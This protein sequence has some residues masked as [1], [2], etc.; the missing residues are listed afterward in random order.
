MIG[1]SKIEGS[2]S[3]NGKVAVV[4]G[5]SRGI[6]RA[7]CELLAKKGADLALVALSETVESA[8]K[9]IS[10]RY[11]VRALPIRGD[12]SS[13]EDVDRMVGSTLD[14]YGKA[15]ILCA[16]AGVTELGD[17]ESIP[18]ADWDR[19][20]NI[21]ARG[22]F[23]TAQKFGAQMIRAG[24]GG[25]IVVMTSQGGIVALDKH[26]AYTMSKAALIGM[27]KSLAYEW[28]EYGINVNGVAPTVVLTEM[29][30]KAWSGETGR[31]MRSRIP[32][33]RF[34]YPDEVA[35]A[36]LFLVS[37]ESRMITGENLIIDG[38]YTIY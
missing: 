22:T 2:C 20:M 37:D 25:K 33:G 18:M 11:G 14:F 8:A 31:A 24:N 29:G 28:A 6:G 13:E 34:A 27:I 10:E 9:E 16:V 35:A 32:A 23:M 7:V 26:V 36:V 12:I 5:A 4:T 21:N 19:V 38:G 15:D 30:E 3:L 1:Y 17:A